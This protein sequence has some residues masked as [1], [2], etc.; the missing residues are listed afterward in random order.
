MWVAKLQMNNNYARTSAWVQHLDELLVKLSSQS[1][2]VGVLATVCARSPSLSFAFIPL[3]SIGQGE[4]SLD[5]IFQVSKV[6]PVYAT[7][8][9]HTSFRGLANSA[10]LYRKLV[11]TSTENEIH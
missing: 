5:F 4:L 2:H 9:W 10:V 6:Y 1:G 7:S 3:P 8:H 11:I